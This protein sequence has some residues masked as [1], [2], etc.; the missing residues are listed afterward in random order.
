MTANTVPAC[1]L[2]ARRRPRFDNESAEYAAK[3][4]EL[5]AEEIEVRRHL[6]RLAAQN[7]ALPQGP[8][9]EG[10]FRF[11]DASGAEIGLAELFGGRDTLVIYH[12]MYGPDRGR[13]CP[14][15]TNLLGPLD[16]NAA[17]IE[18][19]VALAVVGRSSVERQIAFAIERGWRDLRFFQAKGDAFSLK[20]G[21]LDPDNGSEMPV[22]M[23]LVRD[24]DTVRLHWMGE[25][26]SEMADPG[27]D[28][29]GQVDLAPLWNVLDLTPAGR[30]A[31]W[32]P[33]LAYA[34]AA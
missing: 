9:I 28:P 22:L 17:D 21:G 12:W 33:K 18:Q 4:E 1:E 7:R 30:G 27:E 25:M 11:I 20:I 24:G 10:D 14:M 2:A 3:R 15:C 23:V 6:G 13:P 5:L 26:G 31:E 16:G 8:V 29:R 34:P 19:R 32:Y